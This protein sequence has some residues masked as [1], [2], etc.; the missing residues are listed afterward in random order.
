MEV[1]ICF[2]K[3][4]VFVYVW[5]SLVLVSAVKRR[6]LHKSTPEQLRTHLV[7]S[8]LGPKTLGARFKSVISKKRFWY[9]AIYVNKN[10]M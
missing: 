1:S 4:H 5:V 6:F 9:P 2:P 10:K 7:P 3:E 8:A